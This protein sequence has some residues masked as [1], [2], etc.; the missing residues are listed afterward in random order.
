MRAAVWPAGRGEARRRRTC[1]ALSAKGRRNARSAGVDVGAPRAHLPSVRPGL[2]RLSGKSLTRSP[3]FPRK[4]P[5]PSHPPFQRNQETRFHPKPT[6]SEETGINVR[7]GQSQGKRVVQ[8]V[9]RGERGSGGSSRDARLSRNV[10]R[11]QEFLQR[12]RRVALSL[13]FPEEGFGN[14]RRS[15]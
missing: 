4:C 10:T 1:A 11:G 6:Q 8:A 12:T 7:P 13:P 15:A 14:E 2:G 9:S 3:P 5:R